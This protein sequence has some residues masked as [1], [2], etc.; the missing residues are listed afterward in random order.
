MARSLHAVST[1]WNVRDG[2]MP[3]KERKPTQVQQ[4]NGQFLPKKITNSLLQAPG[5]R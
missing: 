3:K 1:T 2:A 4:A 5:S